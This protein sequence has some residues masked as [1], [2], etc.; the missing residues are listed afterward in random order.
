M[1]ADS[2]VPVSAVELLS[3]G[4][5]CF[6]TSFQRFWHGVSC[7][8]LTTALSALEHLSIMFLLQTDAPGF[9]WKRATAG[10]AGCNRFSGLYRLVMPRLYQRKEASPEVVWGFFS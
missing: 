9:S 4:G 1:K 3:Y 5:S 7:K 8:V 6:L 10:I 2:V